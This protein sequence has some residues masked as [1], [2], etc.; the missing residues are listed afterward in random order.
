MKLIDNTAGIVAGRHANS[1]VVTAS[2]DRL[3][4]HNPIYVSD[5]LVVHACINYVGRSSMEI[6][7]R[8]EAENFRTGERRHTASAYL[9]YVALDS[10]GKPMSV[11]PLI[12]KTDEEKRRHQEAEER[13]KIRLTERKRESKSQDK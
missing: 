12:L 1:N 10:E 5:L 3:D 7:A 13:R 6:G 11:P 2:I 4:F 9:T 8:V